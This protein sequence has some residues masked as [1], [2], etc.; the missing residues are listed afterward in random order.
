MTEVGSVYA[1]AL[2]TLA[3][4]E[5]LSD[6]ILQQL[7][8]LEQVLVIYSKTSNSNLHTQGTVTTVPFL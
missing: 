7:K 1:E 3:R 2:Y 4:E 8:T 6:A 5:G